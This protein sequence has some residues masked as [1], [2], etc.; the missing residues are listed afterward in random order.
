MKDYRNIHM[1]KGNIYFKSMSIRAYKV[2]MVVCR[3]KAWLVIYGKGPLQGYLIYHF[4]LIKV[5]FG[6]LWA[7]WRGENNNDSPSDGIIKSR[8]KRY[9]HH[10]REGL[11]WKNRWYTEKFGIY[12]RG[13]GVFDD[14]TSRAEFC[15]HGKNIA[16]KKN[17]WRTKELLDRFELTRR[18]KRKKWAKVWGKR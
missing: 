13:N 14:M 5:V 16:R 3:G 11:R 8:S 6:F 9:L 1:D 7:Q 2:Y 15:L 10:W 4:R 18:L 12:P 17:N